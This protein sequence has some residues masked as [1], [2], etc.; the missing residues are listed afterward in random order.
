MAA[1]FNGIGPKSSHSFLYSHRW[2]MTS[3]RRGPHIEVIVQTAYENHPYS[4]ARQMPLFPASK[5]EMAL[6]WRA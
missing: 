4:D 2:A 1:T 6:D 3:K 5:L